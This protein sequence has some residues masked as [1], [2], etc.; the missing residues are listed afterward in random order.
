MRYQGFFHMSGKKTDRGGYENKANIDENVMMSIVRTAELFKKKAGAVFKN[1][2]LTF[3]QY[4]V[5]R[6]L[7]ASPDGKNT[8][9]NISRIMLVSGA[10]MTGIVKRL[11]KSGFLLKMGDVSDDRIRL[12]EIT[13]RGRDALKDIHTENEKNVKQYMSIASI[14]KKEEILGMLKQIRKAL[15]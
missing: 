3:S 11:E 13:S 2:G 10:N 5:L 1:H 7:D 12:V 14:D 6:I 8:M 9:T 15:R 4:N